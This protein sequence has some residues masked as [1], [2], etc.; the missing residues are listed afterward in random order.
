MEGLVRS[1]ARRGEDYIRIDG[2]T[3]S[4]DRHTR[5]QTFQNNSKCRVALLSIT[6]AGIA[7][8]LTAAATVYFAELYWTPGSLLQVVLHMYVFVLK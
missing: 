2:Q 3:N 6:A 8:T 1:L 4:K 5:V 7:L